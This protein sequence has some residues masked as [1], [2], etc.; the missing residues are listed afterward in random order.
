MRIIIIV[1]ASSEHICLYMTTIS[2]YIYYTHY[3]IFLIVFPPF[4]ILLHFYKVIYYFKY[5]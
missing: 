4:T 3:I 2:L 5:M 1:K